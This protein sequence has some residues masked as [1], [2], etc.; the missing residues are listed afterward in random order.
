MSDQKSL[1]LKNFRL[2]GGLLAVVAGSFAFGFALVPLY[3]VFCEITGFGGR[4]NTETVAVEEAPDLN[5]EIRIE[6]VT[7]LNSYAQFEFAADVPSMV[8]N[9]GK[10]YYAT[11]T[12]RNLTGD[13]TIAQAVPSVAPTAAASH[14]IKIECFCFENQPFMVDEQRPLPLQFYVDPELP[15]YVDTITLQYTFFDNVRAA[16]N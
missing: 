13:T 16:S 1:S 3:D 12:A 7:T 2:I 15:D 9:P 8:V 11:F 14:F 6:F 4:T 5:R 10:M